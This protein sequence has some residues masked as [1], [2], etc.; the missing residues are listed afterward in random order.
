MSILRAGI[1]ERLDYVR[2]VSDFNRRLLLLAV[3]RGGKG[4]FHSGTVIMGG[5]VVDPAWDRMRAEGRRF[6]VIA[7]FKDGKRVPVPP[8][9]LYGYGYRP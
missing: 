7:A 3:A 8:A 4:Y 6:R 5:V 2:V 1:R 9:L